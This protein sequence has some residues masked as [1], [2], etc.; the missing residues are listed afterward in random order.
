MDGENQVEVLLLGTNR[1][2]L[3]PHHHMK[4]ENNYVGP[5]TFKGIYGYE[6]K[7]VNPDITQETTWTQ[8]YSFVPF[9]CGGV[10]ESDR[11][12]MNPDTTPT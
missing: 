5:N 8:R 4:G 9:G 12:Q 1:N 7:I 3:G 2:L 6:D 10:S 11:I